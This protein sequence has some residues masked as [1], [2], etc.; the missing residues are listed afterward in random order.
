MVLH[1]IWAL[2]SIVFSIV[3]YCQKYIV[4]NIDPKLFDP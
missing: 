1:Y 2:R 4:T 3:K